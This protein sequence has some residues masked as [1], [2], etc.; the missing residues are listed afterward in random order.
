M[1]PVGLTTHRLRRS[2]RKRFGGLSCD[3]GEEREERGSCESLH[4][5]WLVICC[6]Y[7][8]SSAL[9]VTCDLGRPLYMC[10]VQEASWTNLRRYCVNE[11]LSAPPYERRSAPEHLYSLSKEVFAPS[12]SAW[13]LGTVRS[14]PPTPP[15]ADKAI[16]DIMLGTFLA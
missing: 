14:I 10:L 16:E 5:E 11:Q 2:R 8:A 12:R 4:D 6:K 3:N 1:V 7:T 15:E 9:R 13:S